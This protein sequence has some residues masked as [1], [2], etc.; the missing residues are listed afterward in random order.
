[1]ARDG[2]AALVFDYD[3]LGKGYVY[4]DLRNVCSSLGEKAREAFLAAYGPFD[5]KEIAVDTV[6]S[7]LIALHYACQKKNPPRYAQGVLDALRGWEE[8]DL[9]LFL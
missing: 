7:E 1:V 3:L 8:E 6:V 9:L 5:E 4:G 2:S